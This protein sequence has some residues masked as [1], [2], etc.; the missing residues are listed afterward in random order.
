MFYLDV[1]YVYDSF[2]C[3]LV[4]L[5]VFPAHVSSVSLVLR[6]MFQVLYLNVSK[7]DWVLH[8]S[9]HLLLPRLDVAS[10]A[11]EVRHGPLGPSPSRCSSWA[12]GSG[13][14]AG[15]PV[16]HYTRIF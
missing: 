9:P 12:S 11:N 10:T 16:F 5:Q 15:G 4:F 14:G 2:K 3:F 8:L 6:H 7:V 1:A 13:G